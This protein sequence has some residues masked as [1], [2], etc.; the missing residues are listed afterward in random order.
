[1]DPGLVPSIEQA[2]Q[3]VFGA[4]HEAVTPFLP[5]TCLAA[6]GHFGLPMSEAFVLPEHWVISNSVAG[7]SLSN[8]TQHR[9]RLNHSVQRYLPRIFEPETAELLMAVLADETIGTRCQTIEYLYHDAGHAAGL[10][11][12]RKVREGLF[13]NDWD[14]GVEEWRADGVEFELA[15]R[16]QPIA[17]LGQLVA[18]NFCLRFGIDAQRA[19]TGEFEGHSICS[20]LML[21]GLLKTGLLQIKNNQ[22]ALSDLSY[23]ALL[24]ATEIQRS[25]AVRITHIELAE[26][27]IDCY[28]SVEVDPRTRAI[29]Q[30]YVLD[31]CWGS[32]HQKPR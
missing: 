6:G 31:A 22:L 23:D 26:D 14:G 20:L 25:E 12:K 4:L 15:Q 11:I 24:R 10:G 7:P 32:K 3:T 18:A 8:S 17:E 27:S 19:L 28:R 1:L 16:T 9:Q 21:D 29:F 13:R 2:I 30:K 5:F